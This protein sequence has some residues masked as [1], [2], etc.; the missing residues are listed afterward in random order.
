M[1]REQLIKAQKLD[2]KRSAYESIIFQLKEDREKV[3]IMK[4]FDG[5]AVTK[6]Y[7]KECARFPQ[8]KIPIEPFR[9]MI[10]DTIEFYE[11]MIQK[12]SKEFDEL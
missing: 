6:I 1:T 2:S 8:I 11:E 5:I 3:Q 4:D 7:L 9:K 10:D 12:I